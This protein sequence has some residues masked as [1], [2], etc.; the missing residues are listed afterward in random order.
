MLIQKWVDA[1]VTW[2]KFQKCSP[3]VVILIVVESKE[4]PLNKTKQKKTLNNKGQKQVRVKSSEVAY[5]SLYNYTSH[6]QIQHD[7]ARKLRQTMSWVE[8]LDI[9]NLKEYS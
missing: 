7:T 6:K 5:Q 8:K 4:T 2:C 3:K 9:Y 1:I